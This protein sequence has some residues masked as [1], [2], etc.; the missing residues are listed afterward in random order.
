MPRW[1]SQ[2][3]RLLTATIGVA[4]LVGLL[5]VVLVAEPGILAV[6]PEKQGLSSPEEVAI[7]ISRSVAIVLIPFGL[8]YAAARPDLWKAALIPFV[9]AIVCNNFSGSGHAASRRRLVHGASPAA[10]HLKRA[11]RI[12]AGVVLAFAC[13]MGSGAFAQD[14]A[15]PELQPKAFLEAEKSPHAAREILVKATKA[16][17]SLVAV[18]ERGHIISVDRQRKHLAPGRS[19]ADPI[20]A[21]RRAFSG[22]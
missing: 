22:P 4:S 18:G 9:W 14:A 19:C 17:S 11:R 7:A 6:V 12:A 2:V 21:Y 8:I 13:T 5:W 16:G 3:T 20:H 1:L 15:P 10:R